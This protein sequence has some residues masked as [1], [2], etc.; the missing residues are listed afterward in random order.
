MN[1]S[2]TIPCSSFDIG[3]SV[4]VVIAHMSRLYEVW[5]ASLDVCTLSKIQVVTC[6]ACKFQDFCICT[7]CSNNLIGRYVEWQTDRI[8]FFSIKFT[9]QLYINIFASEFRQ[10]V[11]LCFVKI[12]YLLLRSF[13]R[14]FPL[15][16]FEYRS[17]L[18]VRSGDC[19]IK[20]VDEGSRVGVAILIAQCVSAVG[21]RLQYPFDVC[22]VKVLTT[23]VF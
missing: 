15:C 22:A 9:L 12:H 4:C 7:P 3:E 16:R 5:C 6:G 19:A 21:R 18:L 8:P 2:T 1:F 10:I 14:N 13:C 23:G 20:C 17:R 11:F